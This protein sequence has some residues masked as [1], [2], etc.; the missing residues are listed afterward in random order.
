MKYGIYS[1]VFIQDQGILKQNH[2]IYFLE[3]DCF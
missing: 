3:Y 1:G 2:C